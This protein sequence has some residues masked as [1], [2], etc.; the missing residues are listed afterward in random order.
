ME[1]RGRRNDNQ[2]MLR[3]PDGMRDQISA[4]AKAASRSVNSE[5]ILRLEASFS[6]ASD[7]LNVAVAAAIKAHVDAEVHRRLREIASQIGGA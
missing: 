2:Y 7:T 1:T 4:A 3:L 6:A 5:I